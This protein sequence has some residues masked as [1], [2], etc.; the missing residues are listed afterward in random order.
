MIFLQLLESP[1]LTVIDATF[2]GPRPGE[3]ASS[4][5]PSSAP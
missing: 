5:I 4:S 3:Y 2:E 1:D